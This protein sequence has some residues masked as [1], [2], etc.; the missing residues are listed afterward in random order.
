[1]NRREVLIGGGA[2]AT[3]A[4]LGLARAMAADNLNFNQ[5]LA[6]LENTDVVLVGAG[7]SL[8][9]KNALHAGVAASA[10]VSNGPISKTPIDPAAID[11]IVYCEVTS[12]KTYTKKYTGI[13]WPGGLSG[14]TC[15]IGYDVGYVNVDRLKADWNGYIADTDIDI[16]SEACGVKAD[17]AKKL[18]KHMPAVRIDYDTAYRQFIEKDAP[19]YTGEVENILFNTKYLSPKSLGALVSLDYNRGASF[20][21]P[22]PKD[23][24]KKDRYF[25]MRNIYSHMQN[26]AF[27]LIPQEIRDMT[28]LWENDPKASGLVIRRNLEAQLFEEG[29][30]HS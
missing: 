14:A 23:P 17:K 27:G 7:G 8:E 24:H 1:M 10:G 11:L 15:G 16:L 2:A 13:I 5:T 25:E 9:A 12:K 26:K 30:A 3:F 6:A 18:V 28:R 22:P 19:R 29:L 4:A 21:A 20:K